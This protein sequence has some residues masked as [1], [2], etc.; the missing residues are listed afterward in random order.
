MQSRF[1]SVKNTARERNGSSANFLTEKLAGNTELK[2]TAEDK[3]IRSLVKVIHPLEFPPSKLHTLTY[4]TNM[5]L[6]TY[7]SP[8][9][10]YQP[11][12]L[13]ANYNHGRPLNRDRTNGTKLQSPPFETRHHQDF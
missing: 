10:I 2:V 4:T 6:H 1:T 9:T 7:V 5:Y 3:A 11:V 13:V 8:A 12:H